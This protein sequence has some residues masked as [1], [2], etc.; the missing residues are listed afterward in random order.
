MEEKEGQL[1]PL[2]RSLT[3]LVTATLLP[4][5]PVAV[6]ASTE[7]NNTLLLLSGPLYYFQQHP[8]TTILF[9]VYYSQIQRSPG[10]HSKTQPYE[11]NLHF[12]T[13]KPSAIRQPTPPYKSIF[14]NCIPPGDL[15]AVL[16]HIIVKCSSS[17]PTLIL[18]TKISFIFCQIYENA[19]YFY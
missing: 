19:S 4:Q 5:Q 16:G 2:L 6:V 8:T 17:H 7:A 1:P 9:S 12:S 13:L 3:A 15:C 11:T 14:G 10:L 18:L